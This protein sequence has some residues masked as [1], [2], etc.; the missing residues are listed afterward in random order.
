[1]DDPRLKPFAS[2]YSV[3]RESYGM[4]PLPKEGRAWVDEYRSFMA[5]KH[6]YDAML[7]VSN[8]A[9]HYIAF[10]K[11]GQSYEWIGEQEVCEGPR[12]YS[13]ENGVFN[14]EVEISFFHGVPHK[15]DGLWISYRGPDEKLEMNEA[16]KP[17]DVQPLLQK[18]GCT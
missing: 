5:S 17:S 2:M 7:H 11:Q 6:G 16:L 3:S 9:E 15:A 18:W 12:K 14:E 10:R 1:M 8:K 4:T 13:S